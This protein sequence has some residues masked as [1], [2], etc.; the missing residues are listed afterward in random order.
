LLATVGRL[1]EAEHAHRLAIDHLEKLAAEF[2]NTPQERRDLALSYNDAAWG[3][4]TCPDPQF[5]DADRAVELAEKA[6]GLEPQQ[7]YVWN[8]L[9]V[10]QYRAGDGDAA[11]QAL[12]KSQ[13][14]KPGTATSYN[15]FFLAMAHWQL[16]E[17]GRRGQ[18]PGA[19]DQELTAEQRAQHK[20]DARMWY[21]KAVKWMEKNKPDDEEL[22]RFRREAEELIGLSEKHHDDTEGTEKA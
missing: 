4:A 19:R 6:V 11:I 7:A 15:G 21:E 3:L 13:E 18:G 1:E 9:G 2:R 5:H 14:L 16:G 10:A 12:E 17:P 22:R 20:E 8:T